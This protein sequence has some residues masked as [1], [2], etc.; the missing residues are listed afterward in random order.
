[1]LQVRDAVVE[2]LAGEHGAVNAAMRPKTV[3]LQPS[4]IKHSIVCDPVAI[5]VFKKVIQLVVCFFVAIEQVDNNDRLSQLTTKLKQ[6]KLADF[7]LQ[8]ERLCIERNRGG[9]RNFVEVLDAEISCVGH[10][11]KVFFR[12]YAFPVRLM[13][14]IWC[15]PAGV[16]EIPISLRASKEDFFLG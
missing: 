8:L 2:Q 15:V 4:Q 16:I 1:M 13:G 10:L 3:F 9:T 12:K 5:T 7:R 11:K 14:P 6:P